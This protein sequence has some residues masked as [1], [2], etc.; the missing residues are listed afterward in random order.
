MK[1]IKE[2]FKLIKELLKTSRGRKILFFSFYGIFI[3]T[4]IIIVRF[5]D[6]TNRYYDEEYDK[7]SSKNITIKE[8]SNFSYDYK[9]ILDDILYNY[10]GER[11]NNKEKFTFNNNSYYCEDTN[12]F[13]N[14]NNLWI[15]ENVPFKFSYFLELAN[16]N[17][18]LEKATFISKTEYE[19]G[20]VSY[21]FEISSNTLNVIIDDIHTDFDDKPNTVVVNIDENGNVNEIKFG[22][23]S[24]CINNKQCMKNLDI[25]MYYDNFSEIDDI[26]SP[27]K[28]DFFLK[29]DIIFSGLFILFEV[30]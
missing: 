20:K 9:I 11:Y 24:Y 10:V 29:Y 17:K 15:K 26:K 21:N 1:S 4:L 18:I 7:S 13:V 25:E 2:F 6:G 16:V 23:N 30:K 12:C 27:I 19:S 8:I 14:N 5:S 28:Q 3:I 22:L